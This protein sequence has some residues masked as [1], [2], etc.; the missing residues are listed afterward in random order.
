MPSCELHIFP[1]VFT[2]VLKHYKGFVLIPCLLSERNYN[3][4]VSP[5]TKQVSIARLDWDHDFFDELQRY[6]IVYTFGCGAKTTRAISR[7]VWKTA[8]E[9]CSQ[10]D[11]P[12]T[13][14]F[15]KI[16]CKESA[17]PPTSITNK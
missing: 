3:V 15:A 6:F 4:R 5:G 2:A 10:E 14:M 13:K 16:N 1:R 7:F 17:F 12:L 8:D 11:N 9:M